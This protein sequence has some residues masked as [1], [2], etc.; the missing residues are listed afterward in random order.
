MCIVF[1]TFLQAKKVTFADL[2]VISDEELQKVIDNRY[3][4]NLPYPGSVAPKSRAERYTNY[5]DSTLF[6]YLSCY[7]SSSLCHAYS[8]SM[9]GQCKLSTVC[10]SIETGLT[11][12]FVIHASSQVLSVDFSSV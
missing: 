4:V 7:H 10:I 11:K 3:M 5:G 8:A 1:I 12:W 9:H 6:R 2:L